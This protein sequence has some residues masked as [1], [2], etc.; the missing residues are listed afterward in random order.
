MLQPWYTNDMAM[1]GASKWIARVFQ[2]LMERGPSMGYF[3]KPAKLYHICPKEEEAEARVAFEVAGIHVNFCRGKRYVG[4]FVGLEAMLERWLDPKVKKWVA[5]VEILA[6]IALRFPQTAYVGLALSLQAKWQYICRVVPGAEHYLAPI[7]TTICEKFIPALLQVSDPVGDTF[8]Q[9]LLQGVKMG[10]L[11]LCNPVAST[12]HLHR[13]SVNACDILVKALHNGGGLSAEAHKACVWEA[14]NQARKARL[15][16]EE[17]YLD[18][19]KV[20]GGRRMAKRLERM[21]KTGA[22][23]SAIPNRFDGT[24]LSREEIQ[25]NFA[26]CYGLHPRGLPERCD[27]C[28]EPFLVEH[29][30]SCKKGGF[31][32]QQHD[33]ICEELAHLCSM[34]LTAA[35]ISSEPEIFYG[36]GLNVAQRNASEV[37]GDE[38]CGDVGAHGFWK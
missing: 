8:C 7:K 2:L 10:G 1:M 28:N 20:S 11:T 38:A 18:G 16:E 37:L 19:L 22:W 13:S 34:A 35:G 26:I 9:L 36:R 4:G 24:E 29:G 15:K 32:G 31:V 27:G 14:G 6:R 23:L 21:G 5:G 3:P 17:T 33:D 12:L 30:L 25:D